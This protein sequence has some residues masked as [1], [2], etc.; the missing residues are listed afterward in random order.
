MQYPIIQDALVRRDI[1]IPN[2]LCR[3]QQLYFSTIPLDVLKEMKKYINLVPETNKRF[4]YVYEKIKKRQPETQEGYFFLLNQLTGLEPYSDAHRY[5][6]DYQRDYLDFI[7]YDM[8][9]DL[10]EKIIK[11]LALPTSLLNIAIHLN[12]T[13]LF[14]YLGP[15]SCGINELESVF[16]EGH[17][18]FGECLG[19]NRVDETDI[20][21]QLYILDIRIINRRV[22]LNSIRYVLNANHDEQWPRSLMI[23]SKK[24][25]N[26]WKVRKVN[27]DDGL[28]ALMM[29]EKHVIGLLEESQRETCLREISYIR[30]DLF[31]KK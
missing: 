6:D 21:E 17:R 10:V 20:Y 19:E 30:R 5:F 3:D 12:F 9:F 16:L 4:A 13:A 28:K 22:A 15:F 1:L 14:E 8:S 7:L 23:I 25:R 26:N 31:A 27:V 2:T 29:L 18:I 24:I 11:R